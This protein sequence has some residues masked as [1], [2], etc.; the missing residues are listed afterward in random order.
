MTLQKIRDKLA[1]RRL[2]VISA[3]TGLHYN[4][5]RSVRDNPSSN[6]T[7]RVITLLAE[8]FEGRDHD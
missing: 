1:D 6:P 4:T 2:S 3:A 5:L 8:Y 7:W